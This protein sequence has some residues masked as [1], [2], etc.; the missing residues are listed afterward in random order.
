LGLKVLL[1]CDQVSAAVGIG[2]HQF[3]GRLSDLVVLV[4]NL[5]VLFGLAI[6]GLA[7][8]LDDAADPAQ[9]HQP[10]VGPQ[11]VA[12]DRLDGLLAAFGIQ[13][14]ETDPG[15]RDD[16]RHHAEERGVPT[17]NNWLGPG[18]DTTHVRPPDS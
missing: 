10:H 3:M 12:E 1:Q 7:G 2:T 9:L 16:G 6:S 4:G 8:Y 13:V 5:A 15:V 17:A 11:G 14:P 18:R